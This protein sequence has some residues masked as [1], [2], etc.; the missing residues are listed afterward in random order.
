MLPIF[1]WFWPTRRTFGVPCFSISA[2]VK[3]VLKFLC[4]LWIRLT[5]YLDLWL[6]LAAVNKRATVCDFPF[7]VFY[8]T[9]GEYAFRFSTMRFKFAAT[10][11][12]QPA[13]SQ[14]T[15][16]I[17]FTTF[18]FLITPKSSSCSLAFLL[19]RSATSYLYASKSWFHKC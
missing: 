10:F 19:I 12:F 13:T 3:S 8:L 15:R 5:A 16:Y 9:L 6:C 17:T 11:I 1:Q 14:L 18:S 7:W 4:L 2:D